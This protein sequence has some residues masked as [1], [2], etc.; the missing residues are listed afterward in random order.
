[1]YTELITRLVP[2]VESVIYRK[3]PANISV[4]TV[5]ESLCWWLKCKSKKNVKPRGVTFKRIYWQK[6]VIG[7]KIYLYD[8][9]WVK[10]LKINNCCIV[11]R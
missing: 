8:L 2:C 9:S 4:Y 3:D 10:L 11:I 5:V 1:M 6:N 7:K